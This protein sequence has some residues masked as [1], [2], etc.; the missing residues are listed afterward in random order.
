MERNAREWLEEGDAH[1]EA[2]RWKEAGPALERALALAQL[3]SAAQAR[4]WYRLGN[5]R[6]E[7]GRD[8]DAAECFEKAVSLDPAHAQAW[9][10]LGGARQRLGQ[11]V[12]AI[13]AY[14]RAIAAD[15]GLA[16]P[17]LNLG[18]LSGGEGDHA[19]AAE[20][21]R[22]AL[23][24]HPGD[25]TFLH[26]LAAASG[27]N[28]PARAPQAYVAGLFDGLAPQF[29]KHLVRD[30]EYRI[31][32]ALARLARPA[33]AAAVP[34]RVIDLGCGTGL[35]GAELADTGAELIGVDLSARMLAIA[36]R[37]AVYARLEQADLIDVLRQAAAGSVH[38][39]LAADVF[40]YL[41][42]LE[43]VFG[44]ALLA[45]APG[46]LFGFSV[47]GTEGEG[48]RLK[49]NGRYGHSPRYL[50]ALAM[51]AGLEERCLERARI[52]RDVQGYADGWIALFAK[53][54]ARP[55]RA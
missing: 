16:Q 20:Y 14:R 43:A 37:R 2:Q 55:A 33:I 35:L 3:P 28:S 42:D 38:A 17:Y 8:A 47:E 46:G 40:V 30:L 4:A 54:G 15:P 26:L 19:R 6:E 45:L 24:H 49:P 34:A 36:A 52:R 39:V 18:R 27:E 41:G 12:P 1:Y 13:E 50:R 11:E 32:E 25:P 51:R 9:N 5:V 22:E 48:Y 44:A 23:E 53:P 7:Q 29:E 31:P 21:F 10:N